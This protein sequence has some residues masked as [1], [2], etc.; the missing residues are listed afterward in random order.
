MKRITNIL[1]IFLA[2]YGM[3][4]YIWFFLLPA[5]F[6]GKNF[7]FPLISTQG[8]LVDSQNNIYVGIGSGLARINK[9]D[10]SGDF[11]ESQSVETYRNDFNMNFNQY[12]EVEIT[13]NRGGYDF[14]NV[15]EIIGDTLAN[16]LNEQQKLFIKNK[17]QCEK[18]GI[19][20]IIED[21]LFRDIILEKDG[22]K[23]VIIVQSFIQKAVHPFT[24]VFIYFTS[25]II[26]IVLNQK[27]AMELLKRY[28]R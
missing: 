22:K 8:I 1:L 15:K 16:A 21:K 5:P 20:Y 19:T 11:I 3:F 28:K 13:I 18:D 27:K 6:I 26:L 24:A 25:I 7:E 12:E 23:K 14:N 4:A 9:Y 2:G 17:S 10:S